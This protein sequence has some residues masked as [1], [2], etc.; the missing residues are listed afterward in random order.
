MRLKLDR[1]SNSSMNQ[2][3]ECMSYLENMSVPK[4]TD[5][6]RLSCEGKLTEMNA[7]M[8]FLPSEVTRAQGTIVFWKSSI[9]AFLMKFISLES[10]NHLFVHV[11]LSYSQRQ[12]MIT[13]IEK[14]GKG[15]MFLKN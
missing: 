9:L 4:L 11:Q 7:G 15:K 6:E 14:K 3:C 5:E 12:A 8:R 13:L 2:N 10:Q 1:S